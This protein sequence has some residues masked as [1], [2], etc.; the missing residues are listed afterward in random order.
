MDT[1]EIMRHRP[2][3]RLLTIRT[4]EWLVQLPVSAEDTTGSI[5]RRLTAILWNGWC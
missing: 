3:S 4:R 5:V 1:T 2:R